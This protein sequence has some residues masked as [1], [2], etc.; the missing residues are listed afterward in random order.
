MPATYA[1][2][3]VA[4]DQVRTEFLKPRWLRTKDDSTPTEVKL[5]DQFVASLDEAK[6]KLA[7]LLFIMGNEKRRDDYDA[8]RALPAEG[9]MGQLLRYD[10]ALQEKFDWALQKLPESQQRRRKAQAPVSV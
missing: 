3:L 8:A 2:V 5:D 4:V 1:D 7:N 9:D 6:V 10:K